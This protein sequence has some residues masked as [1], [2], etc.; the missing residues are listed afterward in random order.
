MF[1]PKTSVRKIATA[2]QKPTSWVGPR[3][4]LFTLEPAIIQ[5]VKEGL[6]RASNLTK[7]LRMTRSERHKEFE[8]IKQMHAE[9]G[10]T[11]RVL[12]DARVRTKG[13]IENEMIAL[14]DTFGGSAVLALWALRWAA[15]I[16]TDFEYR[17]AIAHFQQK[18]L[19]K[20]AK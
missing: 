20:S 13:E 19:D 9:R 4:G 8:R 16:A 7:L 12:T 1:P 10:G 18:L 3:W 5:Y 11:L 2:L 15:G 17:E 6:V 14:D